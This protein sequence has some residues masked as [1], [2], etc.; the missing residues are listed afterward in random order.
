LSFLK[1][2]FLS[3]SEFGSTAST[4]KAT[5]DETPMVVTVIWGLVKCKLRAAF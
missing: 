1:A 3:Y 2:R 5:I 4:S